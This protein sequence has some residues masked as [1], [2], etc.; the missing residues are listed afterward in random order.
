[1][2][3]N[4][5][6]DSTNSSF[7]HLLSRL[8]GIPA[9]SCVTT[10]TIT[11]HYSIEG[12]VPTWWAGSQ[13]TTNGN[14][15]HRPDKWPYCH[16]NQCQSIEKTQST[17]ANQHQLPSSELLGERTLVLWHEVPQRQ[18]GVVKQ[19]LKLSV[20]AAVV[21]SVIRRQNEDL[22]AACRQQHQTA[23]TP[24]APTVGYHAL[25]TPHIQSR[26]SKP[27]TA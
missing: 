6:T 5:V 13:K 4:T 14:N 1:M 9:L 12:W 20:A 2:Q 25:F 10:C 7:L 19:Q 22:L 3:L 23:S 16:P 17:D 8:I 18:A 24:A 21:Q 26:D 27:I 11:S 15:W